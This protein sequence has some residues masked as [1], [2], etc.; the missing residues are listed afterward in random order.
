M[1][2][3]HL[4]S[5][6][7]RAWQSKKTTIIQNGQYGICLRRVWG[8]HARGQSDACRLVPVV[9]IEPLHE[10]LGD[11]TVPYFFMASEFFL[12]GHMEEPGWYPREMKKR[13]RSLVEP[14]VL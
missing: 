13:F 4:F 14:Y 10:I 12:A 2:L 1:A 11:M 8:V 9:F 7:G 3:R 6:L 5:S